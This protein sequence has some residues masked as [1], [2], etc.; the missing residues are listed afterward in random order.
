MLLERDGIQISRNGIAFDLWMLKRLSANSLF[1]QPA[2]PFFARL[3]IHWSA[4]Q[5][6]SNRINQPQPGPLPELR[7][8]PKAILSAL[9]ARR[10]VGSPR[11]SQFRLRSGPFLIVQF[12]S[13]QSDG[14]VESRQKT[15]WI[16]QLIDR[17]TLV[18]D[19]PMTVYQKFVLFG[20]AA[21]NGMI[22]QNQAR[23]STSRLALEE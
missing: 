16:L 23:F 21:K 17:R 4:G 5:L 3:A 19:Q 13:G 14:I 11:K 22:F 1:R 18:S 10:F 12:R 6:L 15:V 9:F 2:H 8:K 20:L 7:A